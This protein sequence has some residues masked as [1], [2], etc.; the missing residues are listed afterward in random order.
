VADNKQIKSLGLRFARALQMTVKTAVMFTVQHKS[1][2]R[3]IQQSFDFL[4]ALLKE[5]GQFTFGFIDNQIILNNLL[6]TDPSLNHLQTEFLKRGI[7]AVTF[8]PGLTMGRYK[9]V[10]SLLAVSTKEIDDAGGTLSFL[11]QNEVEGARILPA[12]KNQKKDEDGDT[13][14]D[15]DSEAYIMSKQMAEEQGSRDFMDSIDALLESGCIDPSVRAEVLTEFA[16]RPMDGAGYGVP[17]PVPQLVPVRDGQV[18]VDKA[19]ENLGPANGSG[20]SGGVG[21]AGVGSGG[22]VE[23]GQAGAGGYAGQAGNGGSGGSGSGGPG[24]GGPGTGGPGAGGSGGS[25][26]GGGEAGGGRGFTG[27]GGGG[28][29]G[30]YGSGGHGGSGSG[31]VFGTTQG[32]GPASDEESVSTGHSGRGKPEPG[33]GWRHAMG[34]QGAGS[35]SFMEMVEAS[36]Q[37]SLLEERG[38]PQKSY[39]SLARILRNTGVDKILANFPV[40]RRQELTSLPPEQLAAE[41]IE[42]TALQLAGAKLK[43]AEGQQQ[44]V[45]IEEEVIHV[46]AR[47]LKATHMADR[48]AQKLAKFISDF[49]VPPHL[50]EKIREELYWSTLNGTKRYERLLSLKHYSQLEFRRVIDLAKELLKGRDTERLV[51]LA[52]HYFEFLDENG[53][54]EVTELSRAPELIRS[55]PLA[56]GDFA[57]KTATR[58][59]KALLREDVSELIHMQAATALAVL[60]QSIASFESFSD[61]LVIGGLFEKSL[62]RDPEKHKKCC[63]NSLRRLLPPAATERIIE[64]FLQQRESGGAKNAVTLLRFS[65]PASIESV[66]NHLIA[67]TDARNRLALVRLI[68]QLGKGSIE[69]AYKYLKDERWYVVRNICGVLSELKDPDLADHIVPALEHSDPRVQQAALKA[70]IHSRTVR[71]APVL[72]A[73]LI[74]LAPNVLDEAL[75]ELMFLR[76]VKSLE[77]LEKLIHCETRNVAAAKKAIHVLANI[78]DDEASHALARLLRD[79]K[80]DNQVRRSALGALSSSRS[81]ISKQLLKD[82][83]ATK[84]P[85]AEEVSA[86]L[87]KAAAGK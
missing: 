4:N 77:G 71:A 26:S 51:A 34:L 67:E 74:K 15:T 5:V 11:D 38:D 8:E 49:S 37:R 6:T 2:E 25:G 87:K 1:V 82:F 10:V 52:A 3:P 70:I 48:L 30:G 17:V 39:T 44:K 46:L 27:V 80:L 56:H 47:S 73:S 35:G 54:I 43:S 40:E 36:V 85:L 86:Q 50:Q 84:D 63:G 7:A 75:N 66:F 83:A 19:T 29:G 81:E 55:I 76:H 53:D 68:G 60:G 33:G 64:I 61:V 20:V 69:V 22:G 16:G 32:Q 14:I 28:S 31:L 65:G 9:K 58:L 62:N 18:L 12:A 57:S 45:L 13:I 24:T 72:A 42:D 41:Y 23:A 79:E 59:G 78:D 21:N